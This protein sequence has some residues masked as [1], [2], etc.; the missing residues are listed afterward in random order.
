MA[1]QKLKAV[2]TA[3]TEAEPTTQAMPDDGQGPAAFDLDDPALYLNRE[4]TWLA[5]NRRVL[6]E[7]A[8]PRTPLL[9]RVKF[10][11]IVS[12]NLDEF[13]MKRIGG[14]KQQIAAGVRSLT[15]DGRTPQ[16]QVA[17]CH[18]VIREIQH[19][20]KRILDEVMKLLSGEGVSL[21][22]YKRL[23]KPQQDQLREHFR[24]NIFP[25]LTPLAM[26]PAHPFP[27]ISNL[28]LNLLV[29]LRF[30]SGHDAH[31]ARLKV[32]VNKD[33]STRLIRVGEDHTFVTL[34]DLIGNNLDMLFPGM[35][36]E[37]CELFRVTRNAVVEFEEEQASD[38][39]EMI[40]SELRE[41][42]FAPIVRLEVQQG[43]SA[44]HRGMLAAEL[45]LDE[46]QDVF[47]VD[48]MMATRD[49]F[50]LA[51]IDIPQ[52]HDP[53]HRPAGQGPAQH[54]PHHPRQRLPAPAAPLRAV[55]H[56]GRAFPAHGGGGSQGTGHQDDP[57][58]N[59]R[60]GRHPRLPGQG[61][62]ER[63]AGGGTGRAQG[64]IRRSRQHPLGPSAG[65]GRYPRKLRGTRPQDPQQ[66]DSG[67]AQGLL[68][69][70]NYHPG[71]ARLYTDL[72]LLSCDDEIGQDLTELFNYLT[73]Y[74]PPP[75]YRKILVAPYA[76]KN[77]IIEKIRR[78]ISVHSPDSP[79]LIQM[80][81]NALEDPDV[82]RALY[83]A[84]QAG[85][86]VDLIV[87]DTCRVRPGIPGLS[88]SVRVLSIVGRFLEHARIF[89]F[90]NGGD[91]EYFIGSAD[92]MRRNL[93][94]RVEVVTPVENPELRQELRMIFDVQINDQRSAWDMHSDGTCV[95]R[96]PS[97]DSEQSSQEALILIAEQRAAASQKHKE[98]KVRSQIANSVHKGMPRRFSED[99]IEEEDD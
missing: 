43:M 6:N 70:G 86:R 40:E 24:K 75:S 25:M 11:A 98:K 14:L 59:L 44:V 1:E 91:E 48:G 50:E 4:L 7:A 90:R 69:T 10:L 35:I 64:P 34:D 66:A 83:E 73:G 18:S 22:D 88:T 12:N 80:K 76:L 96:H 37:S 2:P 57:V 85:V 29:T 52:L 26:D 28:T 54:L 74:S 38:L 51:F 67:R 53:P 62:S 93:E 19:E 94:S 8:D 23:K 58:P 81:M 92:L 27:F 30:P 79:G 65:T 3:S 47:E 78:E 42:H 20:H 56:H 99:A 77:A 5:F 71:T 31:L 60:R 36:I 45:G 39:L 82:C 87:R 33:V 97:D 49:L 55:Q 89:Y 15:V 13:F 61:S 41:R 95:Q 21:V 63:Q 68:G 17:E 84:A 9:E 46:S 32:P 16:Q 72:G